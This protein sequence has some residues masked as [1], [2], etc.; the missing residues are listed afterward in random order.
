[1]KTL[2]MF[3]GALLLSSAALSNAEQQV[4]TEQ[5][6]QGTWTDYKGDVRYA[7]RWTF[8]KPSLIFVK[9]DGRKIQ[10]TY[11]LKGNTLIM[12]HGPGV[13]SDEPWDEEVQI[14]EYNG[15]SLEWIWGIRIKLHRV[16]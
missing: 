12:H 9:Y 10:A 15:D 11:T 7:S 14:V 6:L 5:Q 8:K 1:M 16:Q 13:L 4:I 2:A 3:S